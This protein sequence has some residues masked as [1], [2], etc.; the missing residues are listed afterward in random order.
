MKNKTR[1]N[2]E[3][4]SSDLHGIKLLWVVILNLSITVVQILGGITSNSL[5]LI[6]DALHNL[7]DSSA[8]V[9]A[10]LANRV[11]RKE[12]DYRMTF[13]Y[14]RVEIIAAL[15]N[16]I[17]LIAICLFLFY[18]AYRR[19]R[20]SNPVHGSLMVSVA[21]FGLVANLSSMILLRK[22]KENNLNIKAAYLHMLGDAFASASVIVGGIFVWR[23][24]IYWID[25]VVSI[26]IGCY[27]IHETRHVIKE[28]VDILMQSCPEGMDILQ[29]KEQLEKIDNIDNIHHVH[30]WRLDD[31]QVH[32]EA[33]VNLK[34]NIPVKE[35][36]GIR[37][38][39]ENIL[40][41]HFQISHATL[42][43][44]YECCNGQRELIGK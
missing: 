29:I 14:K 13:G 7:G 41:E 1:H 40:K 30:L 25:P 21:F 33:H 38:L 9:I 37:D 35:I 36:T 22:G 16:G 6:S 10:F 28:T 11:S 24:G 27:I 8:L 4:Y 39:A 3:H 43:F 44:G 12:P 2:H 19:L 34:R 17:V 5:S 42:Q 31:S 26:L 15:F 20:F 32:F 18:E 23:F